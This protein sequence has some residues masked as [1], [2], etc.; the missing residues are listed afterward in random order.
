LKDVSQSL[1]QTLD[2]AIALMTE[3][4]GRLSLTLTDSQTELIRRYCRQLE[5]HNAHTNLVSDASPHTLITEH[6]L[7]SLA[8]VHF[9][10]QF[11]RRKRSGSARL[12]LVDVGSGAGLPGV[13]LAIAV[14]YLDVTLVDSVA[15]KVRFLEQ[16][17]EEASLG[18]R[19]RAISG[20]AEELAHQIQYREKFDLATARAVG[21]LPLVAELCMPLLTIGGELYAQKSLAQLD[22]ASRQAI[23][24]LPKLG[25]AI[26]DAT[27]L[28]ARILEKQRV[29][30]VAEKRSHT[31]KKYPRQW[32][33]IKQQPLAD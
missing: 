15:K 24:C 27:T 4:A 18:D 32:A 19:V 14:K 21:T 28:D 9:I 29:V 3:R 23:K 8:L 30:I 26:T 12:R 1:D 20:R 11:K 2:Q 5:Q 17:I 10:A 7:D 31:A 16:F 13:I 33:Q 25:G 6:V 22:E